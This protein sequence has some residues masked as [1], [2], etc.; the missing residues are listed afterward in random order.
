M[1]LNP[2]QR[3]AS[4]VL[5]R[6]QRHT[7]LVGGSRSGKT[8]L[9]IRSIF[10]RAI[11]ARDSRHIALRLH[12]N[13]ARSSLTLD[14]IPK[15]R[16]LWFPQVEL[17]EHRQDGYFSLLN[18]SQIWVGG[19]DEQDRID[20]ILGRE[21]ATILVNECSQVPY[22]A[23]LTVQT[24][25][26][27]VATCSDGGALRQRMY[28]DLNPV[29]RGHWSNTIF[30]DLRDPV[31]RQP[32][33]N[34]EEYAR[35]FLNPD[36]NRVNLSREYIDSLKALPERQ[37]KR[38][39]EGVY[40]DELDNALWTYEI[41]EELRV[42]ELSEKRRRRIVV[43]VDPSGA[44]SEDDFGR[45]EV[46]IVVAALGDDDHAYVLAD[47]SLRAG[48]AVWGRAVVE[49]FREFFADTIL[50]EENFGGEMVRA[51]IQAVD[52]QAPVR[53]VRASRGKVVRAEPVSALYEK[54][55]VH[56]VGR[57]PV[58]EEQLVAFTAAGYRGEA[59]PDRADALVWALTDLMLGSS[60]QGWIEYYSK[61]ADG[62]QG[63]EAG[64]DTADAVGAVREQSDF[65][66]TYDR[67]KRGLVDEDRR[68]CA[69]CGEELGSS[70]VTDGVDSYHGA[71]HG[72]A[73][74]SGG[75]GRGEEVSAD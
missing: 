30:G 48:P 40:I 28:Y 9:L 44:K 61:L 67:V 37:R 52:P 41:L 73:M 22:G 18:G 15:V 23:V 50:A 58:L 24:R 74:K 47:R 14:T 4:E 54:R 55:R 70:V 62:V 39:Y 29:G 57:F 68:L 65:V 16:R 60:A 2:G 6:P 59:S 10:V 25:L 35:C 69:W 31:S 72:A 8:T 17:Q 34:P 36:E 46:G 21:Y 11:R 7:C 71:C 26:A 53:L 13:A 66:D 33:P 5:A 3:R 75:L 64:A 43:A 20:K 63:A 12:G 38:F 32:L 49:A 45:D 19:L 1:R 42:D 51:T 27:Q 56:H